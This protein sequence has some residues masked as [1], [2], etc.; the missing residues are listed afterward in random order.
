MRS[1]RILSVL[2]LGAALAAPTLADLY[3][4]PTK[5]QSPEQQERDE[6][7]CYQWARRE[8]GFDPMEA[9]RT[10]GAPSSEGNRSVAGGAAKGAAAGAAGGAIIGAITGSAGKGAAIGAAS[11]G[12][13]GGMRRHG[14][15]K[16]ATRDRE[17]RQRQQANAYARRRSEYD[18][19]YAVCLEGRGYKVK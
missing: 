18:R 14:Q 16:Q 17:D 1:I 2:V 19:A 5:G 9:P 8:T 6:Y 11:G 10:G 7:E 4:Y 15:N 12:V 3:V 13:I